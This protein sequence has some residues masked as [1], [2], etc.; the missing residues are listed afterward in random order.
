MIFF[1]VP[2]RSRV[3]YV[4]LENRRLTTRR[5]FPISV[6]VTLFQNGL[7]FVVLSFYLRSLSS[8]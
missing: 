7:G 4:R 6:T 8:D 3:G 2:L 1:A 5:V